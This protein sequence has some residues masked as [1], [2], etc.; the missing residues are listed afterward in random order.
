MG[1]YN[2]GKILNLRKN[3]YNITL[4]K[5]YKVF[6]FILLNLKSYIE[7]CITNARNAELKTVCLL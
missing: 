6:S 2:N 3:N 7:T 5:R 1:N 4:L